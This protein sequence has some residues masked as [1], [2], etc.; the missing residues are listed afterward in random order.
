MPKDPAFLFYPNDWLGGTMGMTFEE[1]GAYMDLLMLQF[2]RGH[3]TS[4]MV[5]QVIGQMEAETQAEIL[6]KFKKDNKGLYYNERLDT[7]IEKRKTYVISRNNNLLGINQY[8]KM[9]DID[10]GHMTSHMENENE[11][12]NKDL[13]NKKKVSKKFIPPSIDEVM[14][15]FEENGYTTESAEKAFNY[16]SI[17][18]WH[19]SKG[20][21]VKNWKQ[22]MQAVWFK[23]ENRTKISRM[24][25]VKS[26]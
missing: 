26:W 12:E 23:D 11:N 20:T 19:D 2:N 10:R 4:H 3:M 22:K 1:K 8:S 15:Y 5:G 17:A 16:Y 7:E 24:E 25:E 18:D 13:N 9:N 6:A 21:K 14:Q